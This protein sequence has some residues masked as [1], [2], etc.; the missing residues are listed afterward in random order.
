[1]SLSDFEYVIDDSPDRIANRITGDISTR[2]IFQ[3]C[4]FLIGARSL[5]TSVSADCMKSNDQS[6]SYGVTV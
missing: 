3:I 6:L 2:Y 4:V 1:M 5:K